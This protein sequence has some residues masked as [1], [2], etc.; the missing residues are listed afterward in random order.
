MSIATLQPSNPLGLKPALVGQAPFGKPGTRASQVGQ[1]PG[2]PRAPQINDP[3]G[4]VAAA[5]YKQAQV[6]K[7]GMGVVNAALAQ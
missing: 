7:A 4:N 3:T 2:A 6:L 5:Q 1:V